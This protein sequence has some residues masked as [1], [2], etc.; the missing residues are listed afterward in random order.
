MKAGWTFTFPYIYFKSLQVAPDCKQL[1]V[2]CLFAIV[3]SKKTKNE[4]ESKVKGLANEESS[5]SN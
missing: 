5:L 1:A 3:Y 2:K 4:L